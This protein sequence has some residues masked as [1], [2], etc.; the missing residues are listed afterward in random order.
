MSNQNFRQQQQINQAVFSSGEKAEKYQ[1]YLFMPMKYLPGTN[2]NQTGK[3][4]RALTMKLV[5][6]FGLTSPTIIARLYAVPHRQ[7]LE[8][9]NK[10]VKNCLA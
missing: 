5:A 8:H 3:A 9:L 4:R 1:P 7:A 10:L 6:R 2:N